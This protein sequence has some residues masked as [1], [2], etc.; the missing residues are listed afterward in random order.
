MMDPGWVNVFINVP[1]GKV[2]WTQSPGRRSALGA[3]RQSRF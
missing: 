3:L 1:G 2:V